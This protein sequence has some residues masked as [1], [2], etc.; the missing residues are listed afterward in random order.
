M[1]LFSFF[2]GA[3]RARS[4]SGV[5]FYNSLSGALERFEMPAHAS[6][7]RMYNCGPT[8]YDTSHIGNLCSYIFADTVRRILEY[9][10]FTVKQVINITDF[11]HLSSNEDR[12][13]D[14]MSGAL[15]REGMALSLPNMRL[16][17]DRYTEEFMRDLSSLNIDT[18]RI[19]FPR[20]SDHIPGEIALVK[21]LEEKGY[22][23]TG[24]DGVYFDT[25]RFPA[26]GALG[27]IDVD[28]LRSGARVS[29]SEDKRH[30]SDFLLWK[31]DAQIGWESP[32]GKGFPGWH[33]EC[34]A[35]IN[36]T[37]GKQIDIH[38]GGIDLRP[39]HHNNEI[40]QSECATGKR[41]LSRFWLHH[42]F[43]N[44]NKEKIS[45][46]LGNVV[47]LPTLSEQGFHPLALRYLY[48][49]AHYRSPL[50]FTLESLGAAQ[51]AYARLLSHR[52]ESTAPVPPSAAWR[53]EF[54]QRVSNDV[55]TPGALSLVWQAV[56]GGTL[57]V[58]EIAG[59]LVEAD[60]V[61]GLRLTEPADLEKELVAR[62]IK[63]YVSPNSYTAEVNNLVSRRAAARAEKNWEVAD[64][65]RQELDVLGF[66][67]DDTEEGQ[68][69][70][71][72]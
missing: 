26:Y 52:L 60:K 34:S 11:G 38:T 10:G 40:A 8:V 44:L 23:Y 7:V 4:A 54:A 70:Y 57:S 66:G 41:P 47:S 20:A 58:D 72:K 45:K 71:K 55:D 43:L 33:I 19:I 42:E 9:N 61:L 51:Q 35:M 63:S 2:G 21:T 56:R 16:I 49:S 59:V 32:W 37:L 65:L 25:S 27:S 15:K 36:A 46:S 64:A 39:T 13:P 48:L 24:V 17:A 3:S 5:F 50:N 6:V 28:G 30:P 14:K 62:L 18:S 31:K 1:G 68:Q 12:G 22:T 67:V 29:A 53:D 69:L